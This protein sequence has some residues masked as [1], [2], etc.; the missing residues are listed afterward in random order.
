MQL[1]FRMFHLST[2]VIWVS[3]LTLDGRLNF[4]P[5][6]LNIALN[7]S[8]TELNEKKIATLIN[9]STRYETQKLLKYAPFT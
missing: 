5:Y 3:A 9:I 8:G 4:L 6:P 7:V 1:S 2:T